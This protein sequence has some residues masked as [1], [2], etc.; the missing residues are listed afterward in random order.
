ML[1]TTASLVDVWAQAAQP[2][3]WSDGGGW[4]GFWWIWI[5]IAFVVIV[6]IFGFAGGWGGYRDSDRHSPPP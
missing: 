6:A 3:A 4:W 5:I 1:I 2:R